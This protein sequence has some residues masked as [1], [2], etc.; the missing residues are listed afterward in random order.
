MG[1]LQFQYE[2][3]CWILQLCEESKA[4]SLEFRPSGSGT[5][6]FMPQICIQK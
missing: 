4:S 6:G 2:M 1:L 3:G 5:P